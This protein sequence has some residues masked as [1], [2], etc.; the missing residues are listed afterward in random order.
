MGKAIFGIV[1]FQIVLKGPWFLSGL[2][3]GIGQPIWGT[4]V[5]L[6]AVVLQVLWLGAGFLARAS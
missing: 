5:L 3:Y 2:L 4:V 1:L 6:V